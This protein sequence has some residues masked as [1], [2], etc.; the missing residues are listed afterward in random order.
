MIKILFICHG[1]ICR[2][3]MAEFILKDMVQKQDLADQFYI[4][5]AATSTEEIWNGS[6]NPVYPP[7]KQE[8]KKH[9]LS[10]GDK[11]AILLKRED[12][13]KYDYLIGMD[14]ANIRNMKRILGG[15]PQGKIYKLLSFAGSDRDVADPWYTGHF[16]VTYTDVESGCKGLLAFLM[17]QQASQSP[18]TI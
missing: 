9:G 12:Y 16:D 13:D 10:C 14:S 6:G 7:A 8:L 5:S 1:N 17:K 4:S 3:P 2:S 15:D 11:R 18:E